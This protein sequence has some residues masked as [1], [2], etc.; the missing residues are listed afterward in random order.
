MNAVSTPSSQVVQ[1][2]SRK[3]GPSDNELAA[4]IVNATAELQKA[5]DAA[6]LAGLIVEPSFQKLGARLANYGITSDS[7]VCTVHTYRQ[8]S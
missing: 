8:L 5:L 4:K 2:P 6:V 3:L 7:H 1:L